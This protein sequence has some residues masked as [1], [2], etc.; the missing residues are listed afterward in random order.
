M[1]LIEQHVETICELGCREVSRVI[2]DLRAGR[3]REEYRQLDAGQRQQ[4]LAELQGIMAV[5][6]DGCPLSED[7]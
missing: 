4:L 1:N 6:E 3:E 2:E 5:Y 7:C